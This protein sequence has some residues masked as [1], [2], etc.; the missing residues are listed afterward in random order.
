[1]AVLFMV[2]WGLEVDRTCVREKP[3][4]TWNEVKTNLKKLNFKERTM[5]VSDKMTILL[6]LHRWQ[7]TGMWQLLP[8]MLPS[9]PGILPLLPGIL[10]RQSLPSILPSVESLF[11]IFCY[12]YKD[13]YFTCLHPILLSY[14]I[15]YYNYSTFFTHHH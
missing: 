13:L 15:N 9:L 8:G 11:D 12:I 5:I 1:M 6:C 7:C 2:C 14:L 4:K 10:P 3:K